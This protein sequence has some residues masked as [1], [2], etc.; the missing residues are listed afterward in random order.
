LKDI[1]N[2]ISFSILSDKITESILE[3]FNIKNLKNTIMDKKNFDSENFEDMKL[4]NLIIKLHC[5]DKIINDVKI[6][7]NFNISLKESSI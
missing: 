5:F 6:E 2:K 1:I 3:E 7:N 4:I